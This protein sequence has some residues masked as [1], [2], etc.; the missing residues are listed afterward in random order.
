MAAVV[1]GPETQKLLFVSLG[2]FI[3]GDSEAYVPVT[4]HVCAGAHAKHVCESRRTPSA[5]AS[6]TSSQFLFVCLFVLFF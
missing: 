1:L 3:G 5:V 6:T 4:A 2:C